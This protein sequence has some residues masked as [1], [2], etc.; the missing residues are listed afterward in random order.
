MSEEARTAGASRAPQ[1]AQKDWSKPRPDVIPRSTYFPA[2]MA[3]G[4]TLFFWGLVT[5]PVVLVMGLLVIAVSLVGW[6]GEMR[7][8]E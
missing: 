6:I 8:G 3:F 1:E 4:L 7:H 5:S 2:A